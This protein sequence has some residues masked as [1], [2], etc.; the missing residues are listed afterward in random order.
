MK[1]I[2]TSQA[3]SLT[4]QVKLFKHL[5]RFYQ[6]IYYLQR[7]SRIYIIIQFSIYQ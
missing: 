5:I 1:F 6:G 2:T 4:R 7:R 3:V